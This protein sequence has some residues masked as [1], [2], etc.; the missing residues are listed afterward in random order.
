MLRLAGGSLGGVLRRAPLLACPD[1]LL[2]DSLSTETLLAPLLELALL[3]TLESS[4]PLVD[5]HFRYF[6]RSG[7]VSV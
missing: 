2:L 5:C 6:A 4:S 1:A 3:P 7:G